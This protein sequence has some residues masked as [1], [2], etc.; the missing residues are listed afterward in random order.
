MDEKLEA[1]FA[2]NRARSKGKATIVKK[3]KWMT[4]FNFFVWQFFHDNDIPKNI[5]DSIP[6]LLVFLVISCMI[7]IITH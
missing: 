1:V 6:G 5:I 4:D 3:A 7:Y 2:I